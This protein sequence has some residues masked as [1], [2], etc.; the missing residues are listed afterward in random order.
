[1]RD[2]YSRRSIRRPCPR[3]IPLSISPDIEAKLGTGNWEIAPGR[4]PFRNG[5]GDGPDATW[6]MPPS[7]GIGPPRVVAAGWVAVAET[8][9]PTGHGRN[10]EDPAL[11]FQRNSALPQPVEHMLNIRVHRCLQGGLIPARA[12]QC[13]VTIGLQ[14]LDRSHRQALLDLAPRLPGLLAGLHPHRQ[15]FNVVALARHGLHAN[16]VGRQYPKVSIWRTL[17]SIGQRRRSNKSAGLV[18]ISGTVAASSPRSVRFTRHSERGRS[19][20]PTA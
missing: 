7:G 4:Q 16:D 18:T 15:L 13:A 12:Y 11:T 9:A 19:G 20:S 6:V 5:L 8:L 10:R 3:R 1:M 17:Q 2:A 14:R